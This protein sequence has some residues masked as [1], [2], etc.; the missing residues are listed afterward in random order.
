[1]DPTYEGDR[2]GGVAG[3]GLQRGVGGGGGW[4]AVEKRE[5]EGEGVRGER[6]EAR[7]RGT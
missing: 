1:M 5:W 2:G 4:V 7:V 3:G 6:D